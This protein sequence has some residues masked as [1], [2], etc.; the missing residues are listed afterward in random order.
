M[1]LLTQVPVSLFSIVLGL[2]SLGD[3]W[4]VAAK[5]WS[6]PAWIAETI[7]LV[8]FG[9]WVLLVLL[10]LAKWLFA[11]PQ[12][13]S[14]LHHPVQ[15][16]F[17][18]LVG[19]STILAAVAIVPQSHGLALALFAIG[20]CVQAIYG[21]YFIGGAWM[22]ERDLA[23]ASP[24]LYLPTVA[25]NFITCF[26]AAYFGFTHL[27]AFCFGAGLLSWLALES[28]VSH[29][30]S[31]HR[32]M[33][34]ALRP[35]LG[36]L[37]APPVVGCAGYLFM[38]GGP[39]GTQPDLVAQGLLGYGL[40]QMVL[41]LR[42]VKWVT[43][44]PFSTAYWAFTFGIGAAAFDAI[45]FVLRGQSGSFA[46]LALGLFIWANVVVGVVAA[47]TLKQLAQGKLLSAHLPPKA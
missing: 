25:G 40:L 4:R 9:I 10:Y 6:L 17:V 47:L 23:H 21:V 24:A 1:K 15:S 29:R 19:V 20:A 35:T 28:V 44:Q 43:Q 33:P 13:W 3:S 46:Y 26:A 30:L 12:A 22:N 11:R 8:A 14:E 16:C 37:L 42:L 31:Y 41:Q 27:A 39:G 38:T 34:P 45:V 18:G 7:M 5:A 2:V 36:I 32:S